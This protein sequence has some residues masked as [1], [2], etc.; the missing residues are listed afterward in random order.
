MPFYDN[1]PARATY[2]LL[3][4]FFL[5]TSGP[6]VL[7]FL[8][9]AANEDKPGDTQL[10]NP[11]AFKIPIIVVCFGWL[12]YV[13]LWKCSGGARRRDW[14]LDRWWSG[15]SDLCALLTPVMVIIAVSFCLSAFVPSA[16][17]VPQ[18]GQHAG[19][20]LAYL[21]LFAFA[22]LLICMSC[23]AF[24]KYED[25]R[26]F[27]SCFCALSVALVFFFIFLGM[28]IQSDVA[29][30]GQAH[31]VETQYTWFATFFPTFFIDIFVFPC[32]IARLSN[33]WQE[34]NV[35]E[36]SAAKCTGW[37]FFVSL[38]LSSI[39]VRA[40]FV[41]DESHLTEHWL[42]LPGGVQTSIINSSEWSL[43]NN[44][45]DTA[46]SSPVV[47]TF[48]P[49]VNPYFGASSLNQFETFGPLLPEHVDAV[50]IFF[51]IDYS[52]CVFFFV[53]KVYLICVYITTRMGVV[54]PID[55]NLYNVNQ[56][57]FSL[58]FDNFFF[59]SSFFCFP[60]FYSMRSGRALQRH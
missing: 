27:M 4:L 10:D 31:F 38:W 28:K 8:L 1:L 22:C 18:D 50:C 55:V 35:D 12:A 46:S 48:P 43:M 24:V 33:T 2:R 20:P 41:Y 42:L 52:C 17:L 34:R 7:Y 58:L 39:F 54:V 37:F 49:F 36:S 5:L 11:L 3:V 26:P 14:P 57:F 59:F 13:L 9:V 53:F 56:N 51:Y 60:E 25:Y 19:L 6:L 15:A 30:T 16:D 32:A 47:A 40:L 45:D 23:C 44:D 29:S 21:P